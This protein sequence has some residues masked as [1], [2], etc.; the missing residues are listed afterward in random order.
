[1]E[2]V[3]EIIPHGGYTDHPW[4]VVLEDGRI[5]LPHQ[6]EK[7]TVKVKPRPNET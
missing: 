1:M 6:I 7:I 2:K 3:K 5:L 4:Q